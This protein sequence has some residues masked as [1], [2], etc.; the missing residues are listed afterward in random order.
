[1]EFMFNDEVSDEFSM[2]RY[3]GLYLTANEFRQYQ[4]I[5]TDYNGGNPR[6][7]KLDENDNEIKDSELFNRIFRDEYD[8][9]I[10][11]MVTNDRAARVETEND[12]K[13]FINDNVLDNPDGNVADV[14][15]E[16]MIWKIDDKSFITLSFDKPLKYGEHLRFVGFN[17][18]NESKNIYENICLEIIASNDERLLNTDDFIFPYISTN[19]PDLFIHGDDQNP[20]LYAAS[21]FYRLS[22]YTQ[23]LTDSKV[24]ASVSEQ[25]ERICACIRKFNSFVRVT[26]K[27]EDSIGIVSSEENV[28]FQHIAAP[29]N[30]EEPTF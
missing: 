7:V 8:D 2:H 30:N 27:T 19:N 20:D 11:F 1:M 21:N 10:I 6:V 3:F 17:V 13:N 5:I 28:Y 18:Y 16:S 23:S 4:C 29:N 26:A 12:V 24:S 15:S 9:R 25:I 14:R 22:F